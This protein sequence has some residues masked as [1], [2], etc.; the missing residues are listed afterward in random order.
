LHAIRTSSTLQHQ[1]KAVKLNGLP[2]TIKWHAFLASG[3][4][5]YIDE[6]GTTE[7]A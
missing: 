1:N 6:G 2:E 5:A 3:I 4:K 7:N